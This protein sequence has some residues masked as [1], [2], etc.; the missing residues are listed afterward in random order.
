MTSFS[1]AAFNTA[2]FD[3]DGTLLNTLDDIAEA[4][5]RCLL[6]H[7]FEPH[8]V[9]AFCNL[10]G[11]G[12]DVLFQRAINASSLDDPRISRL[13]ETYCYEC[14]KQDDRHTRLYNGMADLLNA[15]QD[16]GLVLTILTNK[17]QAHAERCV[18]RFL[19]DWHWKI[20]LGS[21]EIIPKK[22]DPAGATHIVRELNTSPEKC[23]YFGDTDV[24]MWTAKK[25][26][27][28]AVGV[29][30]G[31]REKKELLEAGADYLIQ[32][33]AELLE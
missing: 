9:P 8:P 14:L 4:A 32:H 5:N 29:L 23:L 24:D 12:P 19:P 22:P 26:G 1:I 20:I 17:R 18:E 33:P 28:T 21:G 2:V 7:G 25:A 31:F 27:M 10:V 16:A 15:L 3:L 11:D 30:W 13:V 6:L